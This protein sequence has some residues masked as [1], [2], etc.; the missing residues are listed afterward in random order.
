[1]RHILGTKI[2]SMI[3]VDPVGTL[4]PARKDVTQTIALPRLDKVDLSR[5]GAF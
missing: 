5:T 2:N 3:I 1:M 4:I